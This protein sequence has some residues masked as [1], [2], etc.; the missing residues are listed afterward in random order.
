MG[1][2]HAAEGC[3]TLSRCQGDG[4]PATRLQPPWG[5]QVTSGTACMQGS[6]PPK[7]GQSRAGFTPA[8]SLALDSWGLAPSQGFYSAAEENKPSSRPQNSPPASWFLFCNQF[9]PKNVAVGRFPPSQPA[10]QWVPGTSNSNNSRER[11]GAQPGSSKGTCG[12]PG[13]TSAQPARG[14]MGSCLCRMGTG[15]GMG[16]LRTADRQ[17]PLCHTWGIGGTRRVELIPQLGAQRVPARLRP[18]GC[19]LQGRP[20]TR[21]PGEGRTRRC[22][23]SSSTREGLLGKHHKRRF[24]RLTTSPSTRRKKI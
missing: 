2:S 19:P 9:G 14:Q 10:C 17:K 4:H 16:R 23:F 7:E 11:T 18:L 12:Q 1:V 3:M 22:A 6:W 5:Q 20:R 24:W 8:D 21:S 15:M 13:K